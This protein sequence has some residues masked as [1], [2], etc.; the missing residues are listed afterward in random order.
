MNV[1][2]RKRKA[3]ELYDPDEF[4]ELYFKER[5]IVGISELTSDVTRAI[6]RRA[7]Q[8]RERFKIMR[9]AS[10]SN[11]PVN[12][13]P[14]LLTPAEKYARRLVNNRKSSAASR[15]YKE[16]LKAERAF[17]LSELAKQNVRY[18]SQ[19]TEL[20]AKIQNYERST[21]AMNERNRQL[22]SEIESLKARFFKQ[23]PH[24][25]IP[26]KVT[27]SVSKEVGESDCAKLVSAQRPP[28]F[29]A[30]LTPKTAE[31]VISTALKL[32]PATSS[33]TGALNGLSDVSKCGEHSPDSSRNEALFCF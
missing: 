28:P 33:D 27:S 31:R 23:D 12:E 15:V 25:V 3:A 11:E 9:A 24:S 13:S 17:A 8:A 7:D 21:S 32:P 1:I 18:K 14:Q 16:V 30:P 20:T 29:T 22:E 2:P 4:L 26:N 10:T 6:D 19:V 5:G